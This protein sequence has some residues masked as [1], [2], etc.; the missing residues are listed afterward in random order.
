MNCGKRNVSISKYVPLCFFP[1]QELTTKDRYLNHISSDTAVPAYAYLDV[2]KTDKFEAVSASQ[3]VDLPESTIGNNE[4]PTSSP[5]SSGDKPIGTPAIIAIVIIGT[6]ALVLTGVLIYCCKT[7]KGRTSTSWFARTRKGSAGENS[8]PW[9][10][11]T[12]NLDQGGQSPPLTDNHN[13]TPPSPPMEP[14][15]PTS[16][17]SLLS[18][19]SYRSRSTQG[20]H[21]MNH[22]NSSSEPG[23]SDALEHAGSMRSVACVGSRQA[24]LRT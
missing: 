24:D 19:N 12:P 15:T 9:H 7:R 13:G 1:A 10:S 18:T 2:V 22:Y 6:L 8:N 16:A 14:M 11:I 4:M 21:G 17:Q 23:A 5:S 3:A 20:D